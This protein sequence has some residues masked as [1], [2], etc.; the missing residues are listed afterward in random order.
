MTGDS[1]RHG[2]DFDDEPRGY[3]GG[4]YKPKIPPSKLDDINDWHDGKKGVVDEVLGKVKDFASKM[5]S[6]DD[7]PDFE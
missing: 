4:S 2:R 5:K 6:F 3:G 1:G 7:P